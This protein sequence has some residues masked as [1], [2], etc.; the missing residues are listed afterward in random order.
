MEIHL[1]EIQNEGL[2]VSWT[3][4]DRPDLNLSVL[5]RFQPHEVSKQGEAGLEQRKGKRGGNS[6]QTARRL[7]QR[8]E[9]GS[10]LLWPFCGKGGGSF[11][12]ESML[13]QLCE[14]FILKRAEAVLMPVFQ[15]QKRL[16]V[17]VGS[18]AVVTKCVAAK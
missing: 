5:P 14:E 4:K 17:R 8:R 3:F 12:L 18:P 9:F 1:E 2:L 6:V 16:L 15:K 10:S 13:A 7:L 11:T